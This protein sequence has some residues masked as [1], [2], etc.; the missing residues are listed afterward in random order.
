MF[1]S[2]F[3]FKRSWKLP[4]RSPRCCSR[5]DNSFSLNA[6]GVWIPELI[7]YYL[8]WFWGIGNGFVFWLNGEIKTVLICDAEK[9]QN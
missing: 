9:Y 5:S 1:Y 6:L 3:F 7:C 2:I 4:S 8:V